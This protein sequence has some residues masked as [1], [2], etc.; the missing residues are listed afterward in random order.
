MQ[1]VAWYL[2]TCSIAPQDKMNPTHLTRLL[3]TLRKL[4]ADEC[5][6]AQTVLAERHRQIESSIVLRELSEAVNSC[7]RCAG[8]AVTKAGSKG[9]R[10]RFV[11]KGCGKSFNVLT[12]TPLARLR[13][14]DKHLEYA[15]CMVGQVTVRDAA[16][17][18]GIEPR[19]AFLWRHR[20]LEAIRRIQPAKLGG[21]VEADETFFLESFKGS[22]KLPAGRKA[23]KRG[24][25]AQ[26]RGLSKEQI[27][28]LVARDRSTGETLTCRISSR[29][30]TDIGPALLPRLEKDAVLCSDGASAYRIIGK[31]AKIE[32]KSTPKKKAAGIYHIQNVNSYDSRLKNWVFGFFGIATKYLENYLGW[33]RLLDKT[34]H[35]MT[36]RDFLAAALGI[37]PSLATP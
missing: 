35:R 10:K 36:S 6:K 22:R 29:K 33:H 7:P 37:M 4:S 2:M 8:K 34:S 31:Q 3:D 15:E 5:V 17:M 24:T 32:V 16:E 14:A 20:F 18:L 25:P 26:K 30:A 28:V 21:V 1:Q 27:P 9:G 23:K 19:T 13:M 11:C 12:G